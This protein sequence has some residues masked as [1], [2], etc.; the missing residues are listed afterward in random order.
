VPGNLHVTVR[1]LGDIESQILAET[2]DVLGSHVETVPRFSLEVSEV[3]ARP[4][5]R[6]CR[7]L[8][9]A[10]Q[11]SSGGFS[12]LVG[13]VETACAS[14]GIEGDPKTQV[15]HIT[16]ARARKHRSIAGGALER[17]ND[18][19]G[20]TRPTMSVPSVSLFVS[21]LAP[22]GPEYETV[23]TWRLWGE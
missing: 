23:A 6:R 5:A 16:L 3:V 17:V 21:R 10:C 2:T 9:A 19:V 14:L 4:N 8:W 7:M 1:F 15:P 18:A 11:D 13:A 12:A 22:R 20:P